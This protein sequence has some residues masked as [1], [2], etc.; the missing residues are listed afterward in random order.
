MNTQLSGKF[1][2]FGVA[3]L[4]NSIMIGGVAYLFNGRIQ[5]RVPLASPSPLALARASVPTL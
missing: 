1:A 5:A 2:A 3:L 4:V